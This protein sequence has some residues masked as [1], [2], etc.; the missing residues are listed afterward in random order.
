MANEKNYLC[1]VESTNSLQGIR[2]EKACLEDM[3]GLSIN[4]DDSGQD[5]D[6]TVH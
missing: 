2:E 3:S 1:I 4:P 6:I 5:E